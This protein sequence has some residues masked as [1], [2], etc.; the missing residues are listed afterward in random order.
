MLFAI[1]DI[2]TTGGYAAASGITEVAIIITDGE[3]VLHR[4]ETLVNPRRAI[5]RYITSLTGIDNALVA[6]APFFEEVAAEIAELLK[7]KVFVAHNVNF[8]YSFL[9]HH[10]QQS[11]HV[12]NERKLCTVR[13]GKKVLPGLASYSLGNICRQLSIENEARHR[14]GG[15]CEATRQLFDYLLGQDEEQKHLKDFLKRGSKE[16]SLPIHLDKKHID[17]LPYCPGVYYFHD[18]KEKII[19]VGKAKNIRKRVL[20]HFT[21]NNGNRQ[22]QEF[23]RNIHRISC[24]PT[25][26]EL[27]AFILESV[28]I[29]QYWPKY[30]QSQKRFEQR[31]GIYLFEDQ[32]GYHRLGIEKKKKISQ[33][34]AEVN[35]LTEGYALLWKLAGAHLLC[36]RFCFLDKTS[37]HTADD[38]CTCGGACTGD[39][40]VKQYN[41][42]VTAAVKDLQSQTGSFY[43][44]DAGMT[45]NERSYILVENGRFYGMGSLPAG[46]S[47]ENM[48]WLKT[49]LQ[50]YPANNFINHLLHG[51]AAANPE[52]TVTM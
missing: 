11:G 39:V 36:P 35:N 8:D 47:P 45:L 9:K 23:V 51:Y 42:R 15:D 16:Q 19:Y 6:H 30:N 37:A 43:I 38:T 3:K 26:T 29:K 41:K 7:D 21:N 50:P 32:Q 17:G 40:K 1:T 24:A 48:D 44:V 22:R 49:Q 33:P 4:Y 52:K 18:Q 27:M 46:Q 20:S 5:P 25:A 34:V 14:A 10:L 28:E 12:L 2:E 13:Y 31:Y